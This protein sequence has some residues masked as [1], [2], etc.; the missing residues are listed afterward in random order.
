MKKKGI[1]HTRNRHQG[2]Y[3]FLELFSKFPILKDFETLSPRGEQTLDFT[4]PKA[5]VC[6]NQ[7]LLEND[8][9]IKN[10]SV[11]DGYL[12]PGVPGRADYIH[13]LADLLSVS[14]NKIIPR[15]ESIRILD[16]GVGANGIYSLIGASEYDWSF[17]G[18]DI[19]QNALDHLQ[20]ILNLN[21]KLKGK[22]QLRRQSQSGSIFKGIIGEHEK[23]DAT[24]CN[25][26]FHS[27][28]EEAREINLKKWRNLG[29]AGVANFGGQSNELWCDGGEVQFVTQMIKESVCFKDK[30][31][32]F[33]S[34][35]SKENSLE[36]LLLVL[37]RYLVND[38][39]VINLEQGQKKTRILA[40]TF[41]GGKNKF[42]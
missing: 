14:R 2:R 28:A 19:D 41:I 31:H 34:L 9:G 39:C 7:V 16:I 4:N 27:S 36:L 13:H 37:K 3:P 24:L 18:S 12:C 42:Q 25:P 40:W 22:I 30:C 10:W 21:P 5:V 15:G 33:S 1:L 11:P 29:I 35:V 17:I 26:P 8:Y 23:F 32:W 38:Y 20:N 6:L